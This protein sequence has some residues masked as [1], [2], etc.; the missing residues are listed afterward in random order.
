MAKKSGVKNGTLDMNR[1]LGLVSRSTK[2]FKQL[3]NSIC[4]ESVSSNRFLDKKRFSFPIFQLGFCKLD[5][6]L[7]LFWWLIVLWSFH[8]F[9][10]KMTIQTSEKKPKLLISNYKISTLIYGRISSSMPC[11]DPNMIQSHLWWPQNIVHK[12]FLS[13]QFEQFSLYFTFGLIT[14]NQKWVTYMYPSNSFYE[15]FFPSG[16][17]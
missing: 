8:Y 3:F 9:P 13:R 2:F 15:Q 5:V 11:L 10:T 17:W 6:S 14:M 16:Y 7:A 1:L 4:L 12:I